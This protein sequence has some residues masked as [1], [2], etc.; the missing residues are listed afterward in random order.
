MNIYPSAQPLTENPG[1]VQDFSPGSSVACHA[2][3]PG[4][5]HDPQNG[6]PRLRGLARGFKNARILNPMTHP[7]SPIPC[8]SGRLCGQLKS[9]TLILTKFNLSR[10]KKDSFLCFLPQIN[11]I[12]P[13]LA[14]RPRSLPSKAGQA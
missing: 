11:P 7:Q 9:A 2:T 4:R 10:E 6:L 13:A 14:S 1:G 12:Q 8:A 3:T 5:S